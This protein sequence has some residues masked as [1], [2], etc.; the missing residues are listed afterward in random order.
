MTNRSISWF[1][2]SELEALFNAVRAPTSAREERAEPPRHVDA[3]ARHKAP[4]APAPERAPLPEKAPATDGLA[5]VLK[6]QSAVLMELVRSKSM[7]R[8][9]LDDVLREITERT[10]RTLEAARASVWIYD[11]EK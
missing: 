1:P 11:D 10:A 2:K 5:E 9:V 8:G 6:R 3:P 4:E 7:A